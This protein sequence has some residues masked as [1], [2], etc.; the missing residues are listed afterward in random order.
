MA[1]LLVTDPKG[2]RSPWILPDPFLFVAILVSLNFYDEFR[3][4]W[5]GVI[6]TVLVKR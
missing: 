1:T 3:I 2:F 4:E 6:F 5:H